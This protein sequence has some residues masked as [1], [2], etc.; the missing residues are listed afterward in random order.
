M[1]SRR[2]ETVLC[3]ACVVGCYSPPDAPPATRVGSLETTALVLQAV[4]AGT[5]SALSDAEMTVRYL[6]REPIVF[7]AASVDR[8]PSIEAYEI[9]HEVGEENLVVEVRFEADSYHRLDT[10]LSV[11]RG[12]SAGPLT[13]RLARRLDRVAQVPPTGPTTPVD[14][15]DPPAP[16]GADRSAI[17][18]GDRAFNRSQWLEATEAY[19]RMPAPDDDMSEYGRDYLAAK[20]RQGLAHINRSEFGRALEVFEEA[21]DLESPGPNATLHL[22][23]AQCAVGRTEEGRGTLAQLGRARSRMDPVEQSYVS[24]MIA[25]RRGVCTHGEFDRAETTRERVRSGAQ[26]TQELNAFI[27]GARAMSP[28][29]PEVYNAAQDAERRVSAIRRGARGRT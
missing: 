26:A 13:M 11:A 18:T 1:A 10:V 14:T 2:L 3:I 4:D 25:Y 17:Q 20:I 15:D 9:S 6:V 28:A 24:A 12:A 23:G 16:T 5:G 29:P 7:D 27:E 21:V 8:V 19:Q 22:A